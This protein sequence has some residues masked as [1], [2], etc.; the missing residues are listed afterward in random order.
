MNAWIAA[1]LLLT[2]PPPQAITPIEPIVTVERDGSRTLAMEA[3][4][5][6]P[7]AAVWD[8]ISTPEGWRRWAAPVAHIVPDAEDLMET[9]YAPDARPGDATTI[10]Q[11]FLARIPGRML[12]FRTVKA[13]DGFPNFETYRKVTTIFELSPAGDG[14]TRIVLTATG[15]PDTD[16]GRQLLGFFREGNRKTLEKLRSVLARR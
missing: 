2:T 8:A 5:E 6:A 13:P 11:Q 9:S 1:L 7:M 14:R 15:Y 4:I 3:I 12:A 16:A 10:R